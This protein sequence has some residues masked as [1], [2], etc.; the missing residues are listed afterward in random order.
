MATAFASLAAYEW[1]LTA[2]ELAQALQQRQIAVH[3][4]IAS[5]AE[6]ALH[7]GDAGTSM[8]LAL[9]DLPNIQRGSEQPYALTVA[10]LFAASVQLREAAV[11]KGHTNWVLSVAF[12]PDDQRL[13]TSSGDR[14]ARIWDRET[15]RE[16]AVLKGLIGSVY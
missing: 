2:S 10:T 1:H 9:E 14:T 6:E 5:L 4:K 7:D 3:Q 11:F 12:S 8:L 16:L 13:I 15:H